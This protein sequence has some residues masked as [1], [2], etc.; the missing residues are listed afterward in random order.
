MLRM[1][2][3]DTHYP[4]T[5]DEAVAH[6]EALQGKAKLCAGGT[7]L[8]PNMKHGLHEPQALVH[9]GR[10]KELVTLE[11]TADAIEIGAGVTLHNIAHHPLVLKHVPGLATAADAVAG[12]QLRRMGTLGGNLCLD[13][14]CL[15]YNQTYFWREALGFCLKK[16]GSVCH[17]VQGG[18]KCVAA[19][20]NDTATMLLCLDAEV[21]I[22]D[23][24]GP[25]W[26]PLP[27]L[28][29]SDGADNLT[30]LPTEILTKVR[31]PKAPPH[32]E[33]KEGFAKLRHR[34]SIDY[35]MLSVGVRV[36]LKNDNTIENAALI[37]N[38]L[39][40]KPRAI[41]LAP[42][43]GKPFDDAVINDIAAL[44]QK[45]CRPLTNICDD[46]D[47]RKEMVSVFVKKAIANACGANR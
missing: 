36:D 32:V 3:F 9:I 43:F 2:P 15:Y 21:E 38:A 27:D 30:L 44:A 34:K 1:Q 5:I 29:K 23:A 35:P 26:I 6:L 40:A 14:R 37:V 18:K 4:N 13:T 28:Y 47:W 41:K 10:I 25:R 17:V 16:D 31:I 11:E 7:D 39:A 22:N 45:R 8:I 42:F 24:N 20:S 46:P 12:P 19:T 33:R